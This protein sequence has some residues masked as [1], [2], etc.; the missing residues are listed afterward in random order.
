[1]NN[2][3]FS[4]IIV[5]INVDIYGITFRALK[6]LKTKKF[7]KNRDEKTKMYLIILRK[8]TLPFSSTLAFIAIP[9][10]MALGLQ[11]GGHSKANRRVKFFCKGKKEKTK[12]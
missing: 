12:F 7:I 5:L 6:V 4:F 10:P 2:T 9:W 11:N 3:I 1:M 8:I